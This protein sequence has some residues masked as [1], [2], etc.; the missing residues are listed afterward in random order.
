MEYIPRLVDSLVQAQLDAAGALLIRG[1]KGCGKTE[2]ARSHSRSEVTIDDSSTIQA[3]M[4]TDPTILLTGENPRLID[5]WQ[6]QPQLWNSVRHE[7]D[8]RKEKG[9]FILTG[10]STPRDTQ[11]KGLHSG[12][13]R[14]GL[15]TMG[16]M[17]WS[18]RGWSTGEVSLHDIL[19]GLPVQSHVLTTDIATIAERL[20]IGGWPGNLELDLP[21]ARL[22]NENYF[23]ILTE[24]DFHKAGGP[25]RSTA[26]V[27][28][29]MRS[30]A[31]HVSSEA[32]I[33]R[34]AADTGGSEKAADR[35]SIADYLDILNRL[36]VTNDLEAWNTHIRSRA[37]LRTSPKRHLCDSGLSCAA[38]GL[39]VDRLKS[40]IEYLGLLFE[41]AV[42]HDLR[43]YISAA[44]GDVFHYRDSSGLEADAIIELPDGSWS[45]VEVKLGFG[46]VD[47]AARTLLDVAATVDQSVMGKPRALIAITGSGF[48]HQRPD[49]VTVVPLGTLRA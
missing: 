30:L 17:T 39:T 19:N 28:R 44:R 36:M 38:L 47:T 25:R 26:R 23:S 1:P 3:A 34:I 18:E 40:D 20:M 48:A 43:A 14:F 45:A 13:G 4:D 8:Q 11:M 22:A 35:N 31:R 29:V 33:A 41:S 6:E 9:L 49:G 42:I 5:E 46:A 27:R 37:R 24:I 10:S 15:I 32:S 16:T 2:T 7:V 21:T 12:V